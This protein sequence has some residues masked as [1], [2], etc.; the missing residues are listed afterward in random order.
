M[1]KALRLFALSV[2]LVV[3]LLASCDQ[4]SLI[5][6]TP[7][8]RGN[9]TLPTGA[10]IKGSDFYIRIMEGETAVYTGKVNA[11]GSFVVEGLDE[12]KTYSILLSTEELGEINTSRELSRATSSS[13]YG[14]WLRNATASIDE[15][16]GVGSVKVKPLGTIK[17]KVNRSGETEHYDIMVY[18]PGTSYMAVTDA[19][20]NYSI[21][22]VPQSTTA[23]NLR[24]ISITGDWLPETITGVLLYVDNDT[25]NPVRTVAD[26]TIVKNAGTLLGTITKPGASDNSNITVLIENDEVSENGTTNAEGNLQITGIVPGTY[27][28]TISSMGFVTQT[29]N[30]VVIRASKDTSIGEITL[31][32]NGGDITG[33]ISVNDDESR[34]GAIITATSNDKKY[35]YTTSSRIDGEFAITNAYPATYEITI[36]KT[37]YADMVR[38][39]IRVT[40]GQEF[41]LDEISLSSLYGT[42]SGSV[43]VND[44]GSV[45]GILVTATAEDGRIAQVR[46]LADGSYSFGR[47]EKLVSGI[48]SI[49]A[50][51]DNYSAAIRTISITAAKNTTVDVLALQ[52]VTGSLKVTVGYDDSEETSGITVT[53]Y[54]SEDQ[55]V[56]ET[57]TSNSLTVSFNNVRI[58]L[59]YRVTAE[60]VG[61]GARAKSDIIVSSAQETTISIPKLSNNCGLVKGT[62]EDTKGNPIEN[63]IVRIGDITVFTNADGIFTK[64]G[65]AVGSYSVTV[66][67]DGY[68]SKTLSDKIT[69]EPSKETDIGT[70]KIAS[71]YGSISGTV[72]T[73]DGGT[74]VGIDVTVISGDGKKSQVKTVEGGLYSIEGLEPGDYTVNARTDRYSDAERNV[75]VTADKNTD[76]D[77][78]VLKSSTG[79]LKVTV[80]YADNDSTS[81]ITVSV[82]DS[83]DVKLE[84]A[85]TSDSLTIV[86]SSI[87]AGTGYKVTAEA[88]GYAASIKTDVSVVSASETSLL[89]SNLTS[90]FGT[91]TGRITDTKGN[92]LSDVIV[93]IGD[94]STQP[95][96]EDGSFTRTG[97][98]VGSFIVTVSKDSYS[99]KALEQ[100]IVVEPSSITSIGTV[101]L[102]SLFGT[103]SGSVS[104]NDGGSVEGILVTATDSSGSTSQ[105]RTVSD[106][107]YR[108]GSIERLLPG[109][110]TISAKADGYSDS[111]Q[112]IT[113]NADRN[114]EASVLMLMSKFGT[115]SGRI[116]DPDGNP[117]SG[118]SITVGSFDTVTTKSDGTFIRDN[119]PTGV[120]DLSITKEGYLDR[121][122]EGVEVQ[123]FVF[124]ELSEDVVMTPRT[125][126]IYGRI[127]IEGEP[128]YS[129]VKVTV[130]QSGNGKEYSSYTEADGSFAISATEGNY[131]LV[132]FSHSC[133]FAQYNLDSIALFANGSVEIKPNGGNST[134][135]LLSC[136]HAFVVYESHPSTCTENGYNK[137]RCLRCGRETTDYLPLLEHNNVLVNHLDPTCTE[138]GWNKFECSLCGQKLTVN[139]PS[140]GHSWSKPVV[141]EAATCHSTGSQKI[142]CSV[143]GAVETQTIEKLPH[144]W[145]D[146]GYAD[147]K[148]SYECSICGETE[149]FDDSTSI[150]NISDWGSVSL[151]PSVDPDTVRTLII[152]S[153][154]DGITVTSVFEHTFQDCV[155]ITKVILPETLTSIESW[156][157]AGCIGITEI[158]LPNSL[159]RIGD[160]AF[161]GCTSLKA[162]VIPDGIERIEYSTF[163]NCESLVSVTLPDS[164]TYLD[165]ECFVGCG[166]DRFQIP[167]TVDTLSCYVFMNCRNLKEILIPKSVKY[168]DDRPFWDCTAL[169]TIYVAAQTQ[170]SG[171]ITSWHDCCDASIRWGFTGELHYVHI[172]SDEWNSSSTYHWHVCTECGEVMNME[173]HDFNKTV[174]KQPSCTE[175]GVTTYTCSVCGREYTEAIPALG[176]S[177]DS[178]I[179]IPAT[180][181][182]K[183]ER[184]YTCSICSDSYTEEI[185]SHHEYEETIKTQA[186]CTEA[187]LKTLTCLICDD[188]YD[189]VIPALGHS[190]KET[191]VAATCTEDGLKSFTCERCGD[192]YTEVIPALGHNY[193]ASITKQANCEEAGIKTFTCSHCGDSYTE[194]IP[195]YGH[196]FTSW[197]TVQAATCY[198]SGLKSS[199]C[200][201]CGQTV[202]EE[203]PKLEHQPV[204]KA[205][206]ANHW[207][208]CSLCGLILETKQTHNYV[209]TE[210]DYVCNDC[211]YS[212]SSLYYQVDEDGVLTPK[213]KS[214]L[215]AVVRIP[216]NIDGRIVKTIGN[217]AFRDCTSITT[218]IISE[219]IE[220]VG[221]NAFWYCTNITSLSLPSTLK[222]VGQAAFRGLGR[223]KTLTIP[224]SLS[225]LPHHSFSLCYDLESIVIE[226]GVER[227][228]TYALEEVSNNRLNYVE[229]PKSVTTIEGYAFRQCYIDEIHYAGTI[230]DWNKIS[231]DVKWRDLSTFN[232]IVCSDGDIVLGNYEVDSNGLFY[233]M[234]RSTV[235]AVFEV[236][237]AVNGKTVTGI[238][239]NCFSDCKELTR[240]ILPDTVTKLRWYC[241]SGCDNLECIVNTQ[242]IKEIDYGVFYSC[243]SLVSLDFPNVEI[244][245]SDGATYCSS[246]M[247]VTVSN[248]IRK[249]PK[250]NGCMA[251]GTVVFQGTVSEWNRLEKVD[252]WCATISAEYVEC[253]DGNVKIKETDGTYSITFDGIL[254]CIDY[255]I[256]PSECE[257][258]AT[259]NG[260]AVKALAYNFF[261]SSRNH[262]KSVVIPE[263]VTNLVGATFRNC[264]SL[265]NV[266]LPSTLKTWNEEIFTYCNNL[267]SVIIPNGVTTIGWRTFA[268]CN[269]LEEVVIPSSVK[270]IYGDAFWSCLSLKTITIPDSVT[271]IDGEVFA[272]SGLVSIDIPNSVK[273]L[274]GGVLRDC[275]SLDTVY[276]SSGISEIPEYM[277]NNC[278]KLNTIVFKGTVEKWNSIS[279]GYSW[280]GNVPATTVLCL[281][282]EVS[283]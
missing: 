126:T 43:S 263:G 82:F 186:T 86:F 161:R 56:Y 197:T 139:I 93:H 273:T 32:A 9:V 98:P 159:T 12:T 33:F 117:L 164:V 119:I 88:D 147:G 57:T 242:N 81:G 39:N 118:V 87:V 231:I 244:W 95:T 203:I 134:E 136:S 166:F 280:N 8:I 219:G 94:F 38:P 150:L 262:F 146:K 71:K 232:K 204:F 199:K 261:D 224:G 72:S 237:S 31:K 48:Y 207:T 2:C 28:V 83:S 23:Y 214:I 174:T 19:D 58:G 153:E 236:P 44:G 177:Y 7:A 239:S 225:Y 221:E 191:V 51:A 188:S 128:D 268:D 165:R 179:T 112:T 257:I 10:D 102:V 190:Y 182:E 281:D 201:R 170:P 251:L 255:S 189:E 124:T 89:I 171:W 60:A 275:G 271:R 140:I 200:F 158:D 109:I 279:K 234:D 178:E 92:P 73:N 35:S 106:G 260:I 20:G 169:S 218:L 36:T 278:Y 198:D 122:I 227:I 267:K 53:L 22:N 173:R 245:E 25:E 249:I 282:G 216:S 16:A 59:G 49:S 132:E 230:A 151:K 135:Y 68:T 27:K 67:K 172:E 76:V 213:D 205:D 4:N 96:G 64:S 277:F 212:E 175:T 130:S 154:I 111:E 206:T 185:T 63:A 248:H 91:V 84:E 215:P 37:G 131:N 208:E 52:S 54:D 42:V 6:H 152:P 228:G 100:S 256:L 21:Y 97:I 250:F 107:S 142:T 66:S 34:A 217:D 264:N 110:Y 11:D 46:T 5:S 50:T 1:K 108:F 144:S 195:A 115:I 254:S 123:S 55:K 127:R 15:Q 26:K 30:D 176:H 222:E 69:V 252:S 3:F 17:G 104:I 45:E 184:T 211:G 137:K 243:P 265:E 193:V 167:D 61:Y 259:V 138:E 258:P 181:T 143:C 235:G 101:Q 226:E 194:E 246:L 183:G 145:V 79:I 156:A 253:S 129:G 116:V 149:Q 40:A 74:V 247:T 141:L 241:F 70:I 18:I 78:L 65:I 163:Y 240:V 202:T 210:G 47:N 223:L 270:E 114:V 29:I 133:S 120:Y 196:Y 90:S 238:G 276:I 77:E 157:F 160:Q 14:G 269:S 148:I 105:V 266:V 283:I 274:G 13:G 168:V 85:I 121:I 162:I 192:T 113:V 75:A 220:K 103:I 155:N 62:V 187:G 99:T 125:G 80:G 272:C 229:I 233:L 41:V 24:C 180:C 209:N